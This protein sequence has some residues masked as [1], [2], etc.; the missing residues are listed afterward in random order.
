MYHPEPVM[1]HYADLPPI[2]FYDREL[3]PWLGEI[4][5]RSDAIR[6]ESCRCWPKADPS[7]GPTSSTR[8]A[9]R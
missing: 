6:D 7:S 1:F 8:P 4:E 5:E 3:F 9:R 2:Q